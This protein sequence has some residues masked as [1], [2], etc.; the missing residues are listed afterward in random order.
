MYLLMAWKDPEEQNCPF[1]FLRVQ[2]EILI[3]SNPLH[4]NISIFILH[5]V[6]CTF[7]MVLTRRICRTIESF[8]GR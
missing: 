1:G 5:T 3:L 6:L 8:F 7:T 4:P 2:T